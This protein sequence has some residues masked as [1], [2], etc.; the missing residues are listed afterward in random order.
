M[1]VGI[2]DAVDPEDTK[3][4]SI[5]DIVYHK[6]A[7]IYVQCISSKYV[8]LSHDNR[9]GFKMHHLQLPSVVRRNSAPV[10]FCLGK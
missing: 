8:A 4:Q 5:S 6:Y 10:A 7:R 3:E 2:E 1:S 9:D